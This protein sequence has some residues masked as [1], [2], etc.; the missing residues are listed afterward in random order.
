MGNR[1][2]VKLNGHK[3]TLHTKIKGA[4]KTL[5]KPCSVCEE[6]R[7]KAHCGCGRKGTATGRSRARIFGAADEVPQPPKRSCKSAEV[8]ASIPRPVG[9]PSPDTNKRLHM[10]D[11]WSEVLAASKLAREVELAT[12]M[13][14]CVMSWEAFLIGC[15]M[16]FSFHHN[17]MLRESGDGWLHPIQLLNIASTR[18]S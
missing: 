17:S 9:K 8:P 12:Y 1:K 14:T 18:L 3:C 11:W 2:C 5:S 13:C 4:Q 7:C 6:W 15:M 16:Q 10:T